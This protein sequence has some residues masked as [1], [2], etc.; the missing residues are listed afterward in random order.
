MTKFHS[1]VRNV[2]ISKLL[3]KPCKMGMTK[4]HHGSFKVEQV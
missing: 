1:I 3:A 4:H 2:K